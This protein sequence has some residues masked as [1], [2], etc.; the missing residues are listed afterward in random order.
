MTKESKS[1][2]KTRSDSS[3]T[4]FSSMHRGLS[5]QRSFSNDGS[6]QR[7]PEE[8]PE[9]SAP[10]T[11]FDLTGVSSYPQSPAGVQAKLTV[12]EPGDK[13]EQEADSVAAKVVNQINSPQFQQQQQAVQRQE[14]QEEELQA[15]PEITS[16]QEHEIFHT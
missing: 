16:L 2:P 8:P 14:E 7:K 4:S 6:V 12:G 13:Y 3:K 5:W 11:D 15:K 9:Y 1:Q 10:G